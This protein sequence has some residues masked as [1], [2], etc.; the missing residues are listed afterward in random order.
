MMET[1]EVKKREGVGSRAV[2]RLRQ[3]GHVPAILYGHG[4]A[5]IC[6]SLHRDTVHAI[7]KHGTKLVGLTG[8]VT[9][10]AIVRGVQWDTYGIEVLHMDFARVSQTE[11]VDISL[12]VELHGEA[13]GLMQ[14]GQLRFATHELTISCPA[15]KIPEHLIANIGGLNVGQ[16][17]HAS[18]IVLPEG[19]KLVSP[20]ELVVVAIAK[21]AGEGDDAAAATG[22]EPEVIGKKD[23]AGA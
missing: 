18:E 8:E 14:G 11:L 16:S 23:K 19:A 15:G 7:V 3:T 2:S 12:P 10:T 6:L 4:E 9:D 17:I 13:P 21:A 20:G 5:N 22:A 1:I